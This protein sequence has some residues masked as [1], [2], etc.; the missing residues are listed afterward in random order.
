MALIMGADLAGM[1]AQNSALLAPELVTVEG[2]TFMM[3]SPDFQDALEH[4]VTVSTFRMGRNPVA[5]ESYGRF[6]DSLRDQRFALIGADVRTG[7]EKL[8]ALASSASE[9][10]S[11]L[12][13]MP[14][15]QLFRE[16][17]EIAQGGAAKLMGALIVA[18]LADH[19]PPPNFNRSKQP[20]V[21]A[22]WYSAFV[23]AALHQARLPREAETEYASRVVRGEKKLR[24]YATP[25]GRLNKEEV[26]YD[27]TAPAE[28]DDPKF[29]T[30]TNGLRHLAGL[31]WEWQG[32]WY[33]PYPNGRITDPKGKITDPTGPVNGEYRVLRGGS[34]SVN[35]PVNLRAAFRSLYHP[36][37]SY[38][39]IGFRVVVA[40]EDSQKV[41]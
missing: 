38:V 10:Q 28:V 19:N 25:S 40:P 12:A 8:L 4:E 24:E 32:D 7:S 11:A 9:A 16:A 37:V 15:A 31:V 33:R 41:T 17:G 27:T 5:N 20:A 3:G 1:A 18:H 26:C 23:Y 39:D 35:N 22:N 13:K 29:P 30:L 14:I 34:W 2:G 21:M 6:V 36:V